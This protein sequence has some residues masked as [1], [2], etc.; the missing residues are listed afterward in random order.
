MTSQ[1]EIDALCHTV[2]RTLSN[3]GFQHKTPDGTQ[4]GVSFSHA[5]SDETGDWVLLQV[6]THH[7][8]KG[9]SLYR[10]RQSNVLSELSLALG[11]RVEVLKQQAGCIYAIHMIEDVALPDRVDLDLDNLPTNMHYAIPLGANAQGVLFESLNV[12]THILVGGTTQGGKSTWINAALATLLTQYDPDQ[13]QLRVI[14][15]KEVEFSWLTAIPHL[16]GTEVAYSIDEAISLI[17][18][19]KIEMSRRS[20]L[21]RGQFARN[22]ASY[23]EKVP[24]EDRLPRIVVIV[25]EATDLMLEGGAAFAD[26]L[27]QLLC[28]GAALGF[29]FILATQAPNFKVFPVT[30]K[31]NCTTR[32]AFH[33]ASQDHSRL[34]LDDAGAEELPADIRGRLIA[35]VGTHKYTLQGTYVPDEKLLAIAGKLRDG[36]PIPERKVIQAQLSPEHALLVRWAVEN[37]D[38]CFPVRTIWQN[39]KSVVSYSALRDLATSWERRGWLESD[40]DVTK[41][42][43]IT[44]HLQRMAYDED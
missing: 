44:P 18:L 43:H 36:M 41:A 29:N 40:S 17:E 9:V 28:K 8:P 26:P 4:F 27:V 24:A 3:L 35:M 25:D 23:N 22:L 38:G 30:A 6:D 10:L 31:R 33:C 34:I 1:R 32:I 11:L 37:A 15:P 5:F 42:R 14:D 21:L 12:T 7:L 19:C 39:H 13:L 16:G 20:A 2:T